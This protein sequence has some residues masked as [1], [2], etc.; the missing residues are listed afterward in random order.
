MCRYDEVRTA[1]VDHLASVRFGVDEKITKNLCEKIDE[2]VDAYANGD[3]DH[4]AETMS[5]LWE[6]S[7]KDR[8]IVPATQTVGTS[9]RPP[10]LLS[11]CY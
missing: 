2:K 5:L 8:H 6:V 7:K 3:L 1:Q 10:P 9:V 11:S 4:A